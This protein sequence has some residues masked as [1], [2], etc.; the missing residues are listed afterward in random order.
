M[1]N[2]VFQVNPQRTPI[3]DI[4]LLRCLGDPFGQPVRQHFPS[5]EKDVILD[6]LEQGRT[7]FHLILHAAQHLQYNPVR[8]LFHKGVVVKVD[9][10]VQPGAGDIN[11]LVLVQPVNDGNNPQHPQKTQAADGNTAHQV[12]PV[13]ERIEIP[14]VIHPGLDGVT[15]AQDKLAQEDRHEDQ[16]VENEAFV[17]GVVKLLNGRGVVFQQVLYGYKVINRVPDNQREIEDQQPQHH[18]VDDEPGE[19]VAGF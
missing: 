12:V 4:A 7:T 2:P 14:A 9:E 11:D 10:L 18:K 8:Q 19:L 5:R 17:D 16:V 6:T 15:P 3:G 1:V 13:N